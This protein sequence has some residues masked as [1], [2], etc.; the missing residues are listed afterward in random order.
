LEWLIKG[1]DKNVMAFMRTEGKNKV[2]VVLNLSD[3][4]QEAEIKL[5]SFAG[6]KEWFTGNLLQNGN[7]SLP[8]NSWRVYVLNQ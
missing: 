4:N 1:S 5:P 6:F 7:L 8:P 2:V 3:E